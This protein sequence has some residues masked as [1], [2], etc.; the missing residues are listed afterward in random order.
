[1][2]KSLTALIT[3]LVASVLTLSS[4]S[5]IYVGGREL[6]KISPRY[7]QAFNQR[8]EELENKDK[9]NLNEKIELIH[10][11]GSSGKLDRMDNLINEVISEDA[12]IGS[13]Y[14]EV[15]EKYHKYYKK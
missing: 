11:Y 14:A 2:K 4:C 8:A 12:E 7:A 13:T 10:I 5:Q 3:G 1:M 15:G 9:L 6:K